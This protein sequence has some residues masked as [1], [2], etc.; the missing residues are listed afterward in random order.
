MKLS[1]QQFNL[2]FSMM[3][4]S[5]LFFLKNTCHTSDLCVNSPKLIEVNFVQFNVV[6]RTFSFFLLICWTEKI[7][8]WCDRYTIH[9]A[10][11]SVHRH[12]ISDKSL[13]N[14]IYNLNLIILCTVPPPSP[15]FFL[16][17]LYFSVSLLWRLGDS[18]QPL[19]WRGGSLRALFKG[20][21]SSP[22]REEMLIS[23]I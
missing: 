8:S 20:W 2:C 3:A 10:Y 6:A 18:E 12:W 16:S 14:F 22:T 4:S 23:S 11:Y 17:V 9:T 7:S 19:F 21:C 1:R 15:S 5:C 13:T